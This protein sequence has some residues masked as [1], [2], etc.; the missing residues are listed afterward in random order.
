EGVPPDGAS[1]VLR[2]DPYYHGMNVL[3]SQCLSCHYYGGQGKIDTLYVD[4]EPEQRAEAD[5]SAFEGLDGLPEAAIRALA[6]VAPGNFQ[7]EAVES[8]SEGPDLSSY[9]VV[10]ETDLGERIVAEVEPDGSFVTMT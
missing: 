5:L 8:P 3:R 2:R 7:P 1:Y 9:R 6:V 4:V 10:G